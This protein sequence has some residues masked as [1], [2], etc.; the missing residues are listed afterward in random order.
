MQILSFSE[1]QRLVQ[2]H[3]N[4]FHAVFTANTSSG[5]IG[6]ERF[7]VDILTA[8]PNTG[9]TLPQLC[10]LIDPKTHLQS[11]ERLVCGV[12]DQVLLRSGLVSLTGEEPRTYHLTDL[13]RHA[14]YTPFRVCPSPSFQHYRQN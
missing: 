12:L 7:T 5:V 8:I 11:V 10:A 6:L 9:A 1:L 14:T 4:G 3:P 2:H 13:A